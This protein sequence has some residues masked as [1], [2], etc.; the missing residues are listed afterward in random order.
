MTETSRRQAPFRKFLASS[1]K[2]A[3]VALLALGVTARSSAQDEEFNYD[4]SKVEAYTL[5]DPLV[6]LDGRPVTNA[7]MWRGQRRAEILQLF[8]TQVYGRRPNDRTGMRFRVTEVRDVLG[9]KGRRKRVQVEF[10]EGKNTFP[11]FAIHLISP[12]AVPRAPVF[13]GMHL[14]D[15]A[16]AEPMPG[17]LLDVE[18]G[19]PLPG[20]HLLETIL[21]RG[22]AIATLDAKDF[23]PDDK[24]RFREGVLSHLYPGRSGPPGPE[25]PGAIAT[26]AWGLSRALDY[27]HCDRDIDPRRVA[28]IGHSRMGK[29]ALWAGAQDQR[30]ALVIS[31]DSGCGGAALSRR[32]FGETVKR[33]NHVFPHWF[34]QNFSKYDDREDQLP[35]DQ[36]ELIALVAPRPVYVASAQDDGWADPRGEFLAAAGADAVYRLLGKKGLGL[37]EPPPLN[38]SAGGSIGYHIRSGK[39]AL[40]DFDWLLYLD[41]ADRHLATSATELAVSAQGSS[42]RAGR[43]TA[44]VRLR[45]R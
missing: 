7:A 14:F 25:E 33:I 22:Y 8:E 11:G 3:C 13:V 41:F 5:P 18:V 15:T 36:H 43:G 26:W 6:T 39:H 27:L 23:C 19:R 21:A 42:A 31:N 1:G 35:V 44:R 17:K 29:T 37:I 32:N 10:V 4:E 45:R 28:V 20:E 12:R 40:T 38:Q 16:A 34:C 9:G 30:F 24:Q 2:V